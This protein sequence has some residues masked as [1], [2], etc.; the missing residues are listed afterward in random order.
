MVW[1]LNG[2][3]LVEYIQMVLTVLDCVQMLS[4]ENV[5]VN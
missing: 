1:D 3:V 5:C 2:S 4:E